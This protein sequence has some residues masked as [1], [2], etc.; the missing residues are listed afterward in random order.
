[1]AAFL[2]SF[3]LFLSALF[4]MSGLNLGNV[5]DLVVEPPKQQS[6]VF[7]ATKDMSVVNVP[8]ECVVDFDLPDPFADCDQGKRW[9]KIG[10][11]K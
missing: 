7:T 1:M 2:S 11:L 10:S 8:Y 9:L 3:I 4:V 6:I 5:I